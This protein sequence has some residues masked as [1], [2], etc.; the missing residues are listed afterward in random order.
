M[1]SLK[2]VNTMFGSKT[3]ENRRYHL[4]VNGEKSRFNTRSLAIITGKTLRS[5]GIKDVKLIEEYDLFAWTQDSI[6]KHLDHQEF[7]RS[8]LLDYPIEDKRRKF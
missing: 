4:E 2:E 3:K 6:W 1:N 5:V 7:D 8:S